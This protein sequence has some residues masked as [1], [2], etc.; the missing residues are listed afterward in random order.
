MAQ[1]KL[2]ILVVFTNSIHKTLLADKETKI[3]PAR[4]SL[5]LDFITKRHL[6]GVWVLLVSF[7]K[8]PSKSISIF[9]GSQSQ[10]A[11]CSDWSY[12]EFIF[13]EKVYLSGYWHVLV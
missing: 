6:A 11:T 4:N 1:T 12:L 13:A 3:V 2:P 10:I 7:D 5:D 9:T 8:W